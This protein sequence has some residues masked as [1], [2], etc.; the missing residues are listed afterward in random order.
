MGWDKMG[1]DS[2]SYRYRTYIHTLFPSLPAL[3]GEVEVEERGGAERKTVES[4]ERERRAKAKHEVGIQLHAYTL[5]CLLP[6]S[7]LLLLLLLLSN[8]APAEIFRL[9]SNRTCG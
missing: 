1:L 6:A 9:R 5:A 2:T 7:L 8:S 4:R 3:K